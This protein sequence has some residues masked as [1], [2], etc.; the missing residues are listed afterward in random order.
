VAILLV[1]LLA[2]AIYWFSRRVIIPVMEKT[3]YRSSFQWDDIFINNHFF[4][5]LAPLPA[6][7]VL[8]EAA[9]LVFSDYGHITI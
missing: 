5:R 6:A 9:D 7:V 2:L 8:Y 3:A 4:N 1:A